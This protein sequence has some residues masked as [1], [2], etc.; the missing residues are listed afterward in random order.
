MNIYNTVKSYWNSKCI[1]ITTLEQSENSIKTRYDL[2]LHIPTFIHFDKWKGKK[3]LEIGCGIGDDSISFVKSGANITILELSD[4]NLEICKNR[5]KLHN[6]SATFYEGNPE[7]IDKIIP[8][9]H[10]DL[11]YIFGM[12]SYT[13][14]PENIL[15]NIYKYMN[16]DTELKIMVY[17]KISWKFFQVLFDMD[18]KDINRRDIIRNNCEEFQGCPVLYT[19]S[20]SGITNLLNKYN[21]RI[22]DIWKDYIFMYDEDSYKN[23]EL[24][25]DK[26]WRYSTEDFKNTMKE[27]LGWHTLINAK[28]S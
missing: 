13:P 3:V 5:F 22:I 17:S 12:L 21:Y 28:Y 27:E 1:E 19:Y 25:L 20:I 14:R 15:K 23:G 24:K 10:F 6:L 26:Y 11:I 16:K 7:D 8:I 4:K 9:Q 18:K 2:Q